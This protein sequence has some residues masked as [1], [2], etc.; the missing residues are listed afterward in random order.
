[1]IQKL[2]APVSVAAVFDHTKRAFVPKK[3]RWDGREYRIEKIGFHHTFREG[4]T[5]FHVFSVSA[6]AMFFRLVLDT[7]TLLFRL[8]EIADGEAD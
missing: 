6:E 4:R 7:E 1:M 5:L 3:V 8:E 2:S